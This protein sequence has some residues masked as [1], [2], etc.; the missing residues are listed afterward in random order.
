[1]HSP[2]RIHLFLSAGIITAAGLQ[3]SG[4]PDHSFILG[5][6]INLIWIWEA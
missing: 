4:L 5:V 3:F 6:I 2:H 1:M